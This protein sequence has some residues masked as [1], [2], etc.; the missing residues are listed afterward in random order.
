LR[1]SLGAYKPETVLR[2]CPLQSLSL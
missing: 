2:H 1:V